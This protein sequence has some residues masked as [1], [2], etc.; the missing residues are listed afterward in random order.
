MKA[1]VGDRIIIK[2]HHLGEP[3][4]DCVV[5]EVRG[6]DGGAP[7]RVRWDEDGH[8]SLF[9]PGPDAD[10]QHFDHASPSS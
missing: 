6:P 3:E 5:L 7:Y 9:F 1:T 10:V 8:E 2:G 4:R